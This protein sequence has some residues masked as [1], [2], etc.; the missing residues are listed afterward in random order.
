MRRSSHRFYQPE[1]AHPQQPIYQPEPAVQQPVYHQEPA[2]A[3]EP[4][5]PQ[6]E[7]KRPPMYYFEEVEEK[8]ARERELLESRYQPIPEPASP[9]ATKPITTPGCPIQTVS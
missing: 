4:E 9:V 7:T 3:A 8:R 5:T 1:A 6:E 2:P